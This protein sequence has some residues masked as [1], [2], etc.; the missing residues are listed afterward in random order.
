V[1]L[2]P[3]QAAHRAAHRARLEIDAHRASRRDD[4]AFLLRM[5]DAARQALASK[6]TAITTLEDE[7]FNQ[8]MLIAYAHRRLR[9]L[10]YTGQ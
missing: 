4:V 9:Q 5:R 1:S 6:R 3:V 7:A 2:S 8:S 10:G